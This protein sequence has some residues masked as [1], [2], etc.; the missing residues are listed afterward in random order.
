M[1]AALIIPALNE[2]ETI[3]ALVRRVPRESAAEVI[4]V[5]NASTDDTAAV[6]AAAGARIV[7]EPRRG[8]GAACWAGVSALP[9]WVAVAAFLDGDGSQ[10]PEELPRVLEPILL[11]RAGLVLGA[12]ALTSGTHPRHAALGT[13]LV[14]AFIRRR[15]GVAVTDLGPFR[16]IRVDLLQRL[17]MRDRAFGWP[18]EMVVKA[19]ALG[20]RIVEVPVTH[21]PRAAGRSKVSGT[22]VG[23]VR[24]GYGFLSAALRAARDVP[25]A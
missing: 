5:D 24:A 15:Y 7:R 4:V 13:R 12:R 10:C 9:P 23:T 22:L 11:G 19:A 17:G 6:A 25:A 21:A 20:A 16:A 2:Q 18:V 14:S 8:Y 3:G 1:K